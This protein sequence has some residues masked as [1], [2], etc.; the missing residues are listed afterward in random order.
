[1]LRPDEDAT[2]ESWAITRD[3]GQILGLLVKYLC[4]RSL[5]EIGTGPQS[6]S[7]EV[8]LQNKSPDATLVT[9]DI[10][11]E[12]VRQAATRLNDYPNFLA[13]ERAALPRGGQYDFVFIDGDHS[14]EAMKADFEFALDC[15]LPYGMIVLH[16]VASRGFID[17]DVTRGPRRLLVEL[18]TT[19][20][21]VQYVVLD[22]PECSRYGLLLL[23][24]RADHPDC[25]RLEA[26]GR[27]ERQRIV[28]DIRRP[29]FTHQGN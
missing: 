10:N 27:A 21:H 5:L 20:P 15:L 16:D 7:T 2:G 13:C 12:F 11:V 6:A 26:L 17:L 19:H 3:E 29:G 24:V 28:R 22:S 8:L 9:C 4:P 18:A 1:M 14:Y 25:G 23:Q